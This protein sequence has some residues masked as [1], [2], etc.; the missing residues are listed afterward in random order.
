MRKYIGRLYVDYIFF[1]IWA[2]SLTCV[3]VASAI[4]KFTG[5][6]E[7]F[8]IDVYIILWIILGL[9]FLNH[10]IVVML[11]DK[12]EYNT[13]FE[14]TDEHF[15]LASTSVYTFFKLEKVAPLR[16]I[17]DYT[18][19]QNILSKKFN[20]YKVSINTGSEKLEFYVSRKDVEQLEK[21]LLIIL[22]NNLN[23]RRYKDE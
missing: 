7:A 13:F 1:N 3:V 15:K 14:I 18:I 4:F 9:V 12:Y 11:R 2:I 20:I 23:Y 10:V 21:Q 6:E 22:E 17:L 5:F 8:G 19:K 16:N